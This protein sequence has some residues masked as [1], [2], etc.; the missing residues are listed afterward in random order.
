MSDEYIPETEVE[1]AAGFQMD[2][3]IPLVL[4]ALSFIVY[5]GW[6]VSN[7]STQRGQLENLI[8]RQDPAVNQSKQLQTSLGKLAGDLLQAAQTD[9]TARRIAEKYGIK[10]NGAAPSDAAPSP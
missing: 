3:F 6:Q 10:E 9:D 8:T 7:A 1:P 2:A 4:L 5:L